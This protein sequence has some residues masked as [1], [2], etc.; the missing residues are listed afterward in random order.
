[1]TVT[2]QYET[3]L[4]LLDAHPRDL[5]AITEM[6]RQFGAARVD[7]GSQMTVTFQVG[8]ERDIADLWDLRVA[9][10]ELEANLGSYLPGPVRIDKPRRVS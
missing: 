5:P 8:G 4:D 9:C 7:T 6:A 1:M 3:T 10:E 2:D